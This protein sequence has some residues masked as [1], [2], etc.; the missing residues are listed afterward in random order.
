MNK[1]TAIIDEKDL[2]GVIKMLLRN[3]YVFVVAL[4]VAFVIARINIHRT[5]KIF[6]STITL[7]LQSDS[8]EDLSSAI[9]QGMG[10]NTN[11]EDLANGTS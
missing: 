7:L 2:K 4:V 10:I 6:A 11:W 8:N 1:S 9:L 5:T 3:W